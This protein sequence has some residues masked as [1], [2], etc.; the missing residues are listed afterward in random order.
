[1]L[2]IF[3][4]FFY[5]TKNKTT[6]KKK[7]SVI[8]LSLSLFLSICKS[9]IS[10][11]FDCIHYILWFLAYPMYHSLLPSWQ[12][13]LSTN[14]FRW[15]GPG[16]GPENEILLVSLVFVDKLTWRYYCNTIWTALR[17][18]TDRAYSTQLNLVFLGVEGRKKI[19]KCSKYLLIIVWTCMI[20]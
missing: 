11:E 9:W 3:A 19:P 18:S 4:S 14:L 1:M 20:T 17:T 12:E 16:L 5:R 2:L 7:K 10:I 8:S 13:Q 6:Q 15:V